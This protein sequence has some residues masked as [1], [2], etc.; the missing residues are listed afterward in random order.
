MRISDFQETSKQMISSK[1][2][3]INVTSYNSN[4]DD[5]ALKNKSSVNEER[6]DLEEHRYHGKG[7]G[8]GKNSNRK[9]KPSIEDDY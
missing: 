3:R 1:I 5:K 8:K 2:P 7:K 6:E 4:T 9:T